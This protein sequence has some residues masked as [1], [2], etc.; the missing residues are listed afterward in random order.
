MLVMLHISPHRICMH[1][2]GGVR[3]LIQG[4]QAS[5]ALPKTLPHPGFEPTSFCSIF[6]VTE[7]SRVQI[8][9]Y[10]KKSIFSYTHYSKSQ[11]FVQKFKLTNPQHFHEFFIQIFLT[12]FLFKSKLSTAKRSKTTTF[13]RVCHPKKLTIFLGKSK[14]NFWRKNYDFEQ[15][16]GILI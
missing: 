7:R 5:F 10:L 8:P 6:V 11:M 16:D 9:S 2:N 12:T 13:S 15:C 3:A 14:L 1:E 4:V